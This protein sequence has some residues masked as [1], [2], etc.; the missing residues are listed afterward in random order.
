M[1]GMAVSHKS[2]SQNPCVPAPTGL[3]H[4]CKLPGWG[5]E[6]SEVLCEGGSWVVGPASRQNPIAPGNT[7]DTQIIMSSPG[8]YCLRALVPPKHKEGHVTLC[9]AMVGGQVQRD[10]HSSPWGLPDLAFWVSCRHVLAGAV[11]MTLTSA[12]QKLLTFRFWDTHTLI[13]L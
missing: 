9:D 10:R 5:W 13:T 3:L 6:P 11:G 8:S 1:C 4:Q 12:H 7:Q 2:P